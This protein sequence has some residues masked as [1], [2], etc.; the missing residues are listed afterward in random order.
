MSDAAAVR[1]RVAAARGRMTVR[2]A[3]VTAA[4]LA[5]SAGTL[6]LGG[7]L[8]IGVKAQL[9]A[10]LIDRAY[11]AHLQ[12]GA[13]HRPWPWADL[14]PIAR[15]EIA[16]LRV[17]RTILSGAAGESLAFGLGHVSG[18]APPAGDGNCAIGGHR[19]TWA[20]FM[21]ELRVGDEMSMETRDNRREYRVA[22]IDVVQETDL[23]AIEP[24]DGSRLTLI[25]CYPFTGLT[26]STQRLIVV[27]EAF[28]MS[29]G[30]RCARQTTRFAPS[31]AAVDAVALPFREEEVQRRSPA[32]AVRWDC[33]YRRRS[34][35]DR[36]PHG[37]V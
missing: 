11:A 28:R 30:D 36:R 17:T 12:D 8:Y 1:G 15:L 27:A 14:Q 31:G 10:L 26:Q 4:L 22:S 23:S 5:A 29:E 13:A 9:A 7:R 18:T 34:S 21:K 3:L 16:R 35:S 33:P 25:T 37:A 6:M 19:D 20:S 24:A 32:S 2:R